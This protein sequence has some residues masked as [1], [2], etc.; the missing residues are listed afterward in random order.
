[1]SKKQTSPFAF[2][3]IYPRMRYMM[4]LGRNLYQLGV[5]LRT[6]FS[7]RP[8]SSS[9]LP[10]AYNVC[11]ADTIDSEMKLSCLSGEFQ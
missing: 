6:R 8:A 4:G 7:H 5:N 1:M 2:Q 11:N 3:Y 9:V 10:D